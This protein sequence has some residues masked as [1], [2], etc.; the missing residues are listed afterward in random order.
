MHKGQHDV[1]PG[2]PD[3]G[4][5]LDDPTGDFS[6]GRDEVHVWRAGLLRTDADV[7]QLRATLTRDEVE[8]AES[9][10]FEKDRRHCVVA[11][12]L[13]RCLLGRYLDSE[14][15]SLRFRYGSYGK[16]EL[17]EEF[18]GGRLRFNVSHSH[19]LV[20][21]AVSYERDV[22]VDIEHMRQD[23]ECM[24][25][26][27]RFFSPREIA[28]LGDLPSCERKAAFFNCWTRKEAFIKAHGAGLSYPLNRFS[29]SVFTGEPLCS[30]EIMG[31]AQEASGWEIR[32][33]RPHPGYAAALAA[34]GN[35]WSVKCW[36]VP[37]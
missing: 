20:I 11:R 30:L 1:R 5:W 37:C 29:V 24:E 36:Q 33:L 15:H 18:S 19:E 28:A 17:T 25:V 16:P 31:D 10:Y 14:P 8:R 6:L 27:Q 23:I 13:L 22:G 2:I 9:F 34:E 21:Y 7:E 35:G 3:Q 4:V 32:E 26:A 12:G